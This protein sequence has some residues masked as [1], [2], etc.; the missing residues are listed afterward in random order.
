MD[1]TEIRHVPPAHEPESPAHPLTAGVLAAFLARSEGCPVGRIDA[2]GA[3]VEANPA[4]RRWLPAGDEPLLAEALLPTSADRFAE[5]LALLDVPGRHLAVRLDFGRVGAPCASF[6]C[7]VHRDALGLWLFGE[8]LA[9]LAEPLLREV[10]AH[11]H[12]LLRLNRQLHKKTTNL[13]RDRADIERLARTDPL[14]G[15]A[16]RR[17][18]DEWLR[19]LVALADPEG[20]PLAC[21]MVDIDYFK[22]INDTFGHPT[23]DRVLRGAAQALAENVR[24]LDRLA[25]VGGEEF[26]VLLP[27]TDLAGARTLAERLRVAFSARVIPPLGRGLSASFGVA[28]FRRG[29]SPDDLLARA[30]DALLRAKRNGRDRVEADEP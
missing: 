6:R 20:A 26:L 19:Q 27:E 9:D 18:G 15:L 10:L 17:Q 14:T 29:E 30:D 2:R 23:G 28:G 21:I 3:V 11:Q 22:A 24:P 16:N 8:R 13:E 4:L 25:R 1:T 12:D 5:V 7:L